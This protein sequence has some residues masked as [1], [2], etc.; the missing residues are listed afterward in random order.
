MTKIIRNGILLNLNVLNIYRRI[1]NINLGLKY[2]T[3]SSGGPLDIFE[4]FNNINLVLKRLEE[5]N[6]LKSHVLI[7]FER[8]HII[9][10]GLL[11]K[12]SIY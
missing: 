11:Y 8:V 9:N 4:R 1:S 3:K 2:I 12:D 7:I 10:L 5:E 6:T